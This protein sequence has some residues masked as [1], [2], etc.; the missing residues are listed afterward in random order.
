MKKT[1]AACAGLATID[2]GS[3]IVRLVHHTF[4]DFIERYDEPRF[5][6]SHATTAAACLMHLC[7]NSFSKDAALGRCAEKNQE[8]VYESIECDGRLCP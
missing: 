5:S 8:V 1:I 6:D 4:K 3:R 2:E 7:Y